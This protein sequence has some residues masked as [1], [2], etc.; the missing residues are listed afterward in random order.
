MGLA[1]AGI[2]RVDERIASA[3]AAPGDDAQ[4]TIGRA[5]AAT[6]LGA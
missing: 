5:R 6:P 4:S 2:A 3:V 1:A